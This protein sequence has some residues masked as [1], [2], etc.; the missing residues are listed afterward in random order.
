M[1][2]RTA[3][4]GSSQGGHFWGCPDYPNCHGVLPYISPNPS[5]PVLDKEAL[6]GSLTQHATAT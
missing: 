2:L 1:V 6:M 4:R 3:K 5:I